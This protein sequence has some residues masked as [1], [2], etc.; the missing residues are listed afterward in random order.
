MTSKKGR[1]AQ[2]CASSPK[3]AEARSALSTPEKMCRGVRLRSALMQCMLQ[4][5]AVLT[6][7]ATGK[8]VLHEVCNGCE[9]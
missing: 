5:E 1:R 7:G 6:A 3:A 8:E 2:E 4:G 9:Y